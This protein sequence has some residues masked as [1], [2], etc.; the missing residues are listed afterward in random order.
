MSS[1]ELLHNTTP[2]T[3]VVGGN[4]G[5]WSAHD[6]A[7]E[8][9]HVSGIEAWVYALDGDY[10]SHDEL[11]QSDIDS[12][13]LVILNTNR[14]EQPTHLKKLLGM[15][16]KR[17][18]NTKVVCLLEGDMR[19]YL[20]PR[21]YLRELFDSVD[22]INCIN[23]HATEAIQLLTHT[24]VHYIGIPYPVEGVKS[25]R[26]QTQQR[27]RRI[28]V[29]PFVLSRWTEVHLG[30]VLRLPMSGYEQQ[31]SRR[32][33]NVSSNYR[34]H[35]TL[36]NKGVLL[37]RAS[38]MYPRHNLEVH[39]ERWFSDYYRH[40]ATALLWLNLDDRYTWGRH[41][42]DAAALGVPIISTR[43]TGHAA[44][45][46]PDCTV[47]TPFDVEA[48][49]QKARRIIDDPEHYQSVIT[50]ADQAL[51]MYRPEVIRHKLLSALA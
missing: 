8:A 36:L 18:A 35:G 20:R 41:V 50:H 2:C 25:L 13:E 6:R 43:S 37:Q 17:S 11:R 10:S 12:H 48:A 44:I 45:L 32:L 14:I 40:A 22:L 28:H 19:D 51:H 42:L 30:Q 31:L 46:F 9:A 21:E 29:C 24:P 26:V 34:K 4:P 5:R 16:Q 3:L 49:A 47:D 38:R 1:Q 33:R 27:E 39:A 15:M 23:V 7:H